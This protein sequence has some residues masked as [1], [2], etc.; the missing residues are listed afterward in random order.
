MESTVLHKCI[1]L[2]TTAKSISFLKVRLNLIYR[3][4][5]VRILFGVSILT[6]VLHK[7]CITT[8]RATIQP[9][10]TPFVFVEDFIVNRY[11]RLHFSTLQHI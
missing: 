6:A 5:K 1:L 3:C 4:D 7:N 9:D 10:K 11:F 8:E 2:E